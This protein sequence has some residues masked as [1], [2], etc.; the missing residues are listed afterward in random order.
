MPEENTFGRFTRGSPLSEH[1]RDAV[2]DPAESDADRRNLARYARRRRRHAKAEA[3][4]RRL[5]LPG[6]AHRG[7]ALQDDIAGSVLVEP[8]DV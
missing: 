5:A 7:L 6:E 8:L 4:Q 2:G 1:R 3:A